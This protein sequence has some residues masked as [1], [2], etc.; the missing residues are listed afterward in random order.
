MTEQENERELDEL[1]WIERHGVK[2]LQAVLGELGLDEEPE[3]TLIEVLAS[4]HDRTKLYVFDLESA[5][6]Y[7]NDSYEDQWAQCEAQNLRALISV[8]QE[9]IKARLKRK[10]EA[11]DD[12]DSLPWE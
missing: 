2:F 5:R 11:M 8:R 3:E 12:D 7:V 10:L 9:R 6:S 1:E 4:V